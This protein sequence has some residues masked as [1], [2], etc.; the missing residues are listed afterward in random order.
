MCERDIP[1]HL[2][3]AFV[4]YIWQLWI[5]KFEMFNELCATPP[6][7]V[8]AICALEFIRRIKP[9]KHV[10]KP[11]GKGT[12]NNFTMR[13]VMECRHQIGDALLYHPSTSVFVNE[14]EWSS[15]L[16]LPVHNLLIWVCCLI[17]IIRITGIRGVRVDF[18]LSD[19]S[20]EW[21]SGWY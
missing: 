14:N 13:I 16:A 9:T 6:S 17:L 12:R 4:S 5:Q 11:T 7:P 19:G 2:E 8:F 15:G 3:V 18:L 20:L 1:N 10:L 21:G